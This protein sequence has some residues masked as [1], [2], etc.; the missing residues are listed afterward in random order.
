MIPTLQKAQK[1]QT[2]NSDDDLTV[3]YLFSSPIFLLNS[4]NLKAVHRSLSESYL[5][6]LPSAVAFSVSGSYPKFSDN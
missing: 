5:N 6:V 3:F 1:Y 4:G 2:T